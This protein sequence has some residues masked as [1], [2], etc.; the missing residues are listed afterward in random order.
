MNRILLCLSLFTLIGTNLNAQ[1]DDCTCCSADNL[2]FDFWVGEWEVFKSDGTLVG[3][4]TISKIQDG[5]VLSEN[6]T[7]ANSSF[8]GT[9]TNFFNNQTGEWEQLWVDNGGS[10]LH[11]R[12]NRTGNQMILVSDEITREDKPPYSNRITWTLNED[13][14]VRQLWEILVDGKV[15]NVAFDGIY[16]KIN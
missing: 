13:G 11:L 5:C 8:T 7:S 10:H 2:A 4:N 9:S 1:S 6:W 15:A 16:R 14:T 12:G 3:T